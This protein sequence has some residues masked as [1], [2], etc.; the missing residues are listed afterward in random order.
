MKQFIIY[1]LLIV[2]V[3]A[4]NSNKRIG[5][6]T[7]SEIN[8]VHLENGIT[9]S[10]SIIVYALPQT[11]LKFK[12]TATKTIKKQG[13]LFRYSERFIGIRDVVLRDEVS[14]K[15]KSIALETVSEADPEH[16]YQVNFSG[17]SSAP[18]IAL[19][20]KGCIQSVNAPVKHSEPKIAEEKPSVLPL[21][22]SFR[23]TPYLEEQV[24]VNSTAKMAE[25]AAHFIYRLRDNRTALVSGELNYYPADGNALTVGLAE[26]ERLESEFLALFIGKQAQ[27]E[28]IYTV[29]YLPKVPI[30]NVLAFRFSQYKGLVDKGDLSG[31]P[32]YLSVQKNKS[33]LNLSDTISHINNRGFF[34][35]V[36]EKAMVI[37]NEGTKTLLT[38]QVTLAQFG[39]TLSLPKTLFE[40]NTNSILFYEETGAINKIFKNNSH[41]N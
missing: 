28:V 38:Q 27:Q 22:T 39:S 23:Y 3:S 5:T 30:N 6:N 7:K 32:I 36:P 29:E 17:N 4:C 33:A 19:N 25:E 37:L 34:Y 16:Y 14:Y 1:F 15:I 11:R 10:D 9:D 26:I 8:V 31:S 40:D 18:Y 24:V 20:E 41:D 35:R 12:I 2:L 13:P 21:D